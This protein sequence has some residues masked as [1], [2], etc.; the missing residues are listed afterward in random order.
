MATLLSDYS[1]P[2]RD[3]WDDSGRHD[4]IRERSGH[5]STDDELMCLV[6]KFWETSSDRH[7]P[8]LNERGQPAIR[9]DLYNNRGGM[10]SRMGFKGK[11]RV[12]GSALGSEEGSPPHRNGSR[13]RVQALRELDCQRSFLKLGTSL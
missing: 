13:R 9:K 2:P 6:D 3:T 10:G 7:V 12:S 8:V 4:G 11:H 5:D 1:V